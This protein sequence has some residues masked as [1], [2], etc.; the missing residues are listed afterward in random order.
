M[1]KNKSRAARRRYIRGRRVSTALF[2]GRKSRPRNGQSKMRNAS[3]SKK[4]SR[5][6]FK[7]REIAK[8]AN[9]PYEYVVYLFTQDDNLSTLIRSHAQVVEFVKNSIAGQYKICKHKIAEPT[10][11]GVNCI[12]LEL[13]S[14][15][16]MLM[17]CHRDSIRK[18]FK[19]VDETEISSTSN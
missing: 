2:M 8:V 11:M 9:E 18:I 4:A 16:M 1:A 6:V 19:I 7:I 15:L 12:K 3:R 10:V 5:P 13:E 17:L 14:D